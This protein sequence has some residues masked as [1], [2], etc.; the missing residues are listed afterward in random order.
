MKFNNFGSVSIARARNGKKLQPSKHLDETGTWYFDGSRLRR[1]DWI[2]DS[3]F[4]N[5]RLLRERVC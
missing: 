4:S 5:A 2:I 1:D 3:P